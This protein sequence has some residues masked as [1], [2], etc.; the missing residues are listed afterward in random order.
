MYA[1]MTEGQQQEK[2]ARNAGPETLE[3][4]RLATALATSMRRACGTKTRT[5]HHAFSERR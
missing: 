3:G 5:H 1:P 2:S 4:T